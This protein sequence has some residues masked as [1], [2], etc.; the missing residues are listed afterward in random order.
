MSFLVKVLPYF[1]PANSMNQLATQS[2][3]PQLIRK[4]T[5]Y[6]VL[7]Q[8]ESKMD[9]GMYGFSTWQRLKAVDVDHR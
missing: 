6:E 3:T 9:M 1:V 4:N 5:F 2:P 7:L 8:I